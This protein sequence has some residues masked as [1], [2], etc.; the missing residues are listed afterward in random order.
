MKILNG[1]KINWELL[2]KYLSGE[3]NDEETVP[4]QEWIESSDKNKI[5]FKNIQSDWNKINLA[6]NM[7]KVDVDNAWENLKQRI[8][9]EEPELIT[10]KDLKQENRAMSY[11][12]RPLQIAASILILIGIAFGTYKIISGPGFADSTIIKSGSDNTSSL[13]LPDGSKVYLNS[14]TII[15]YPERFGTDSRNIYLKGEAYFDA[16]SNPDKP[17]IINT[18]DA[19]IKVLG[20]SFNVNT[21]TANN[22]LEVFV[23][24]G[25]VQLSKKGNK[26]NEILIEPGYIGALSGNNLTKSRNDD[27]NYLAWKTRHLIF[28]D[29]KLEIVAE[30]IGSVYNTSIQFSNKEIADCQLTATFDNAPLDSVLTVI[31]G[32]FNLGI[33]NI[34]KTNRKVI[35]VG[36]G[37]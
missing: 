24:S 33:E 5:F 10:M 3:C 21:K 12:Y 37:C 8:L 26:E 36:N 1:N 34:I 30:K 31:K 32:T 20:T 14:N 35:I 9:Q 25:N 18:S 16:V 19:L 6:R 13:I 15:K 28:R 2:A 17:F 27:I 4:I 7:K 23:E 11:L 22:E 29:T